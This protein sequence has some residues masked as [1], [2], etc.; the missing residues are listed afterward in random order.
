MWLFISG[1]AVATGAIIAAE[2]VFKYS[3]GD[4]VADIFR[5]AEQKVQAARAFAAKLNAKAD[6]K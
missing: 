5:S 4:K 2:I 1:V 6:R 3:L